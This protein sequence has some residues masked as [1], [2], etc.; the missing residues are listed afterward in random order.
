VRVLPP[1]K[2]H[3]LL[4][5]RNRVQNDGRVSIPEGFLYQPE[6]A[7]IVFE[8]QNVRVILVHGLPIAAVS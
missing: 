2:S 3:G 8:Q 6:V 4:A 7:G 1:E 5:V